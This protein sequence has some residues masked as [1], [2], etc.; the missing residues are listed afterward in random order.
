MGKPTGEMEELAQ[1]L[2][3][4]EE[5]NGSD[6][7][8]EANAPIRVIEK[9][10]ILVTRFSGSD[11]FAALLRRATVLSR[12]DMS[13]T[14][15][16]KMGKDGSILFEGLSEETILTLAAHLLDLMATFIGRGLTLTLL[17]EYWLVEI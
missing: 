13:S 7:S 1:K 17:R 12:T 6:T 2:L 16:F 3:A 15:D 14:S 9:L 5:R 11:G 4:L 10:R 8:L